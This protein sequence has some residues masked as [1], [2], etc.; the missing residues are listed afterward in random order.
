[1]VISSY[2]PDYDREIANMGTSLSLNLLMKFNLI[3]LTNPKCPSV[4]KL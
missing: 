3:S 1:M 4:K 2:I